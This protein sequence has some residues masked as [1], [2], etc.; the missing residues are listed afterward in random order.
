MSTYE[1]S[2]KRDLREFPYEVS[3]PDGEGDPPKFLTWQHA[4]ECQKRWNKDCPGHRARKRKNMLQNAA[5]PST[6]ENED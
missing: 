4:I 1:E 5:I 2:Y 6:E 3:H